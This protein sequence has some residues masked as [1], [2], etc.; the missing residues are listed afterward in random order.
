MTNGQARR[1]PT[2]TKSDVAQRIGSPIRLC[3]ADVL[4]PWGSGAP[5]TATSRAWRGRAGRAPGG[6]HGLRLALAS[7]IR[8]GAS[9]LDGPPQVR[10]IVGTNQP[11]SCVRST[12]IRLSHR[13]RTA[14]ARW[15]S[16]QWPSTR[17]ASPLRCASTY[18]WSSTLV[19]D[20][21]YLVVP[22]FPTDYC[23]VPIQQRRP[24]QHYGR[25][26]E[27]TMDHVHTAP[28]ARRSTLHTNGRAVW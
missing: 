14:R 7:L 13:S 1:P 4:H 3:R 10:I 17:P 11:R 23:S 21:A 6:P 12:T 25:N 28:D 22:Q 24:T 8:Q 2:F 20:F 15:R 27:D 16:C 19:L 5:R 9:D 18:K 26:D